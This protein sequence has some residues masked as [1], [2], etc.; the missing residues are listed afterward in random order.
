MA[1]VPIGPAPTA[2]GEARFFF[3]MACAMAA[4]IVAGFSFNLAMGRSTFAVP[5][6]YHVHAAIFMGWVAL[7]LA[8]N[9]LIFS[10]NARLHRRLGWLALLWVP[11]MVGAGTAMTVVSARRAGGPPFFDQSEFLIGNPLGLLAFAGLAGWAIAV[12]ANTGWHRRL[13]LCAM[14]VL[15]GPAF[16]RLLPMPLFIPWG[17]WAA[18]LVPLVFPLLGMA[19]DQ[20][21]YGTA[22][23]AW[24]WGIGVILATLAVTDLIA[25]SPVGQ[26]ITDRVLAGSP[27]AERQ[28]AAFFPP[29]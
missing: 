26:A 11:L 5:P 14:A 27:G 22:H 12:R 13:M 1:T 23:P 3:M 7:Y 17:W 19:A 10:G 20:R 18:N 9:A 6:L 28:Q 25:Y 8:Q 15:T 4:T 24:L 21:R 2:R 29:M 16:G